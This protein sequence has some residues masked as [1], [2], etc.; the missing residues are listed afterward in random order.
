VISPDE[1][2]K[3]DGYRCQLCG[4]KTRGMVPNPKAPTVDHIVPLAHGGDH[5]FLNVQCAC[6]ACNSRKGASA[7]NDQLRLVA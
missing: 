6:F 1:V 4:I 3:R 7:A 5:S 2:F